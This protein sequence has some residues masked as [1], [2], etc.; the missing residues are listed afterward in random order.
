MNPSAECVWMSMFVE[1]WLFFCQ[2]RCVLPKMLLLQA[3]TEHAACSMLS[4][5]GYLITNDS[6]IALARL[7]SSPFWLPRNTQG[8]WNGWFGALIPLLVAR[9]SPWA[10]GQ[11][12]LTCLCL[13]MFIFV[14]YLISMNRWNIYLYT[15][16][17]EN[18]VFYSKLIKV[19]IYNL[20]PFTQLFALFMCAFCVSIYIF[21]KYC[22]TPP[23]RFWLG[24]GNFQPTF[25]FGVPSGETM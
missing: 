18:A 1:F 23:P 25:C 15:N 17:V 24:F 12:E 6:N 13:C 19:S 5:R 20:Y 16:L 3:Y 22:L 9:W 7:E 11:A 21:F 4:L 8:V 10:V 14:F 2:T